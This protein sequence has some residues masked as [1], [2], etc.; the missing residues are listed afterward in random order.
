MM[1]FMALAQECAPHVHPVTMAA[2]VRVE[3]SF[4]PYAIGVV[5]GKLDRQPQNKA[6]AVATA[7]AL[8]QAG[9]NFS[10]GASQVNRYNLAKYNLDYDTAFEPCPNFRAGASIL[11]DCYDRAVVKLGDKQ[12][13]L[14][15]AFSCYYSGNFSTGFKQDFKGQPSYVAKVLASAGAGTATS[16]IPVTA[17][18][19]AKKATGKP[20]KAAS[21]EAAAS[22]SVPKVADDAPVLLQA[23]PAKPKKPRNVPAKYDGF[24]SSDDQT[25]NPY[26]GFASGS[27]E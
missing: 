8:E 27:V 6:E 9:W 19:G 11:K 7:K 16:A 3:S 5:G 17:T 12:Q 24:D 26:D 21:T 22:A 4:N 23:A 1:D 20:T 2:V 14:Q 18:P 10:V 13:A 15:A 25:A